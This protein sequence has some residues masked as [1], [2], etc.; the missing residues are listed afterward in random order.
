MPYNPK[1]L[2]NL[3]RYE[4]GQSG[5]AKGSSEKRR[6]KKEKE[7]RVIDHLKK[8][9]KV[10][11]VKVMFRDRIK[12]EDVDE[13]EQIILQM[14]AQQ[15]TQLGKWEGCPA[16]AKNL[17]VAI[18][19]DMKSGKTT[20]IDRLRDRQFGKAIQRV[21]VTGANGE[22]LNPVKNISPEEAKKLIDTLENEF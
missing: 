17:A 11:D 19:F 21:E 6:K 3:K 15:L 20:T 5:N 2:A 12:M 10:D 18:L 9:F 7:Q 14:T 13:W 1:S 8:V 16:Y 4:P 22:P